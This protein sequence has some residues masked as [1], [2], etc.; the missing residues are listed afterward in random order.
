[1]RGVTVVSALASCTTRTSAVYNLAS[2]PDGT[3]TLQV[4]QTDAQ[5]NSVAF[6]SRSYVLDRKAPAI[7]NF[8]A[9][10]NPFN[11]RK[12]KTTKI[13]F[14]SNEAAKFTLV[15]K[16]RRATMRKL[17]VKALAGAGSRPVKWNG[18]TSK[19]RLVRAGKYTVILTAIDTAGNKVTKKFTLRV[20]R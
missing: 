17:A 12:T 11:L 18:K 14:K 3:Y 13:G 10:R 16:K 6:A 15:I 7:T 5:G 20:K 2:K 4:R 1:M 8:K 19:R 9:T